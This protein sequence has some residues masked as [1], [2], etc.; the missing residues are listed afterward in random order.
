MSEIKRRQKGCLRCGLITIAFTL[1]GLALGI[2]MVL[3]EEYVGYTV[4]WHGYVKENNE[5]IYTLKAGETYTLTLY[6]STSK[7]ERI[8]RIEPSAQR[9]LGL[10]EFNIDVLLEDIAGNVVARVPRT[11]IFKGYE[12]DIGNC[13]YWKQVTFTVPIS[14]T[15]TLR[16]TPYSTEIQRI[17]FSIREKR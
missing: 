14:G 11:D 5:G 16:V 17:D 10:P 1:M 2:G 4:L 15:Y 6:L 3:W 13:H 8:L 9:C 12:S 7:K